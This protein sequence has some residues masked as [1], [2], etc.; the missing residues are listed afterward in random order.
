MLSTENEMSL[1]S[2][3]RSLESEQKESEDTKKDG[4]SLPD[5]GCEGGEFVEAIEI[6]DDGISGEW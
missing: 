5:E 1:I 4:K 3:D 6:A 2:I